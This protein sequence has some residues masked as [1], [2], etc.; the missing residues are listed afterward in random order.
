MWM[1]LT[2]ERKET[3]QPCYFGYA[4]WTPT[5]DLMTDAIV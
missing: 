1:A 4:F 2:S 3:G 5:L